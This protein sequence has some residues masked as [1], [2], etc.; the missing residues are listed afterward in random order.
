[1]S[2]PFAWVDAFTAEPFAGNPAA[3]C[4][5]DAE[6]DEQWM[7]DMAREFGLS[8]TAFVLPRD[9]GFSLRWFTPVVESDLCG[10]ATLA[11]AHVLW[12][13]GVLDHDAAAR[14][15]TRSGE[16]VCARA[17]G[18]IEMD[19]PVDEIQ[20]SEPIAGADTLGVDVVFTGI[21]SRDHYIE[22]ENER[23]LRELDP[24]MS[25]VAGLPLRGLVVTSRAAEGADYALRMFAPQAGIDEDPVTGSVQTALGPFWAERLGRPELVAR[26]ASTRGG[27]LRVRPEGVRVKIAGQA[28]T[29]ARGTL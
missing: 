19:F 14:F 22:V 24:R 12:E 21:S 28:V 23:V 13:A 5:L 20:K 2:I 7:F 27:T 17:S 16:L 26:Q 3:V 4:M 8:E 11:S 29:I 6:R 15:F 10:H 18:W 25:W 9:G 1:M